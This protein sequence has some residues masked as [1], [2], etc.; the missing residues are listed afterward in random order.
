MRDSRELAL[1]I[2]CKSEA[3]RIPSEPLL[4]P[5]LAG[6][7]LDDRDRRLVTA[8][9]QTTHR[10]RGRAD[11]VLD[12]RLTRGVRSLDIRTLNVLR[13]AYVQLFHLDQIPPHA[14]VHT[15]V[16]LAWRHSGEG[17]ARMVN[18]ILRGLLVRRPGPKEWSSGRGAE[19]L[20]GEL[21][22]PAWLLERWVA[23]WGPET[24]RRICE[25]NNQSPD[26]HLRVRGDVSAVA[27]VRAEL[28]AAGFSISPGA[29]L[30]E[31]L[32]VEG[33][34]KVREHP[35]L[36][37]G[38]ITIQDESQMLVGHLWP[39]ATAGPVGDLCAAPGTKTTHVAELC[40][41]SSV[42]ASDIARRRI[43]RLAD[44]LQRMDLHNVHL[45]VADAR[46]PPYRPRRL[47]CVLVDAPCT[48]LGVLQ[49][50]PDARWLCAPGQIHDS[51]VL[52]TQI[53]RAAAELVGEGGWLLYSVCTL[54]TEE[55][56]DQITRF[57]AE[58]PEFAAAALPE[59]LP[60]EIR[61]GE[62]IVRILPG[63][64]GMEGLYAALLQRRSA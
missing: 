2:L 12:R 22:H 11:H 55:T 19:Q 5:T 46:R 33:S 32:R 28:S 17:K 52:Q 59:W 50:R 51:A 9:V 29:L 16:D 10:W 30:P 18:R 23:R 24:T 27:R 48:S 13:L 38:A 47:K 7:S 40:Q 61:G 42:Y 31:A 56:D 49:R 54:E 45:V 44:S 6:S 21:S 15:A 8:L 41:G 39:D 20:E 14:V 36:I 1:Q 4:G 58:H 37:A 60:R 35:L 3:E 43:L 63:T 25:W 57:L 62:G 34:F 26:F 53:L 64:L